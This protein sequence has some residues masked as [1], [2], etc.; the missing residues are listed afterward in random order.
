MRPA[1]VAPEG[2]SPGTDHE[3]HAQLSTASDDDATGHALFSAVGQTQLR[4]RGIPFDRSMRKVDVP[5]HGR[6]LSER[7]CVDE[8]RRLVLMGG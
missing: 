5:P 2:T 8:P 3:A 4:R 6:R 1:S 7:P